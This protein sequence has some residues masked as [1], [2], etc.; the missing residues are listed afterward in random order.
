MRARLVARVAIPALAMAW[1]VGCGSLGP[2]TGPH[3]VRYGAADYTVY[4]ALGTSIS[5]G[6]QSGGLVV[7][8][9]THAFPYLFATQARTQRFDIPSVSPDGAPALLRVLSYQ[10]LII[11]NVGRVDGVNTNASL[12]TAYHNMAVP[13]AVISDLTDTTAYTVPPRGGAFAI[14]QRQRG[15]LLA[16][17]LRQLNPPPTFFSFEFGSNEVLLPAAAG[18]GGTLIPAPVWAG[19]LTAAIDSIHIAYPDAKIALVNVPDVTT[20]PFFTTFPP[21]TLDLLGNPSPLLAASGP[22]G[23]NDFVLLTAAPQLAAGIGFATNARSYVSGVAGTGQPLPDN[24]VLTA[25]EAAP[26]LAAV[27]AFNA[28]IDSVVQRPFIAKVDLHGLL[29]E[30]ATTGIYVQELGR[31]VT[32]AFLTGGLFSLDGAHPNDLAH[33]ILCNAMIVALNTKFGSEI[34]TVNLATVATATASSSRPSPGGRQA[35]P[36]IEGDLGLGEMVRPIAVRP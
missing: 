10:P 7:H 16:Q 21:I 29:T 8:H 32:S 11:S 20:V 28:A 33:G 5:A 13:Y 9:Q 24:L 3:E 12:P 17:V 19:L 27:T 18:V 23:P 26:T 6:W 15:T 14:V 34:P 31:T 1:S 25:A 2:I 22:L 4:A 36:R 35:Y 30:A